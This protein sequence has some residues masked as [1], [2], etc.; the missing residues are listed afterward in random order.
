MS[1]AETFTLLAVDDEPDVVDALRR[2]LKDPRFEFVG[3]TRPAEALEVLT[4]RPV[5]L[6]ISDLDMPGMNGLE[7]LRQVR[8]HHPETVRLVLTGRASLESALDAI[9]QG[10]VHRYLTK[11][12]DKAVLRRTIDDAVDRL[13]EVR[14]AAEAQRRLTERAGIHEALEARYP[15]IT[16]VDLEDGAVPLDPARLDAAWQL[17]DAVGASPADA[18]LLDSE[19][20][21]AAGP[22]DG[23]RDLETLCG[24]VLDERFRLDDLVGSGGFGV[25]YRALQLS[26]DRFVAVKLLRAEAVGRD[27]LKRFRVE[28]L[29][30]CRVAHPHAVTVLDAGVDEQGL[31]YLVME[32]LDGETVAE[33][34]GR[35]DTL[36]F[37][38]AASLAAD[39]CS[40]LSFAHDSGILHCDIK[41]ANVF[42]HAAPDGPVVKLLD[43]GIARLASPQGTFRGLTAENLLMGTPAYMAPERVAGGALD[44]RADVYGMGV[45]LYEML[46][47]VRPFPGTSA[48]EVA[49]QQLCLHPRPLN[50]IDASVPAELD[51][52]VSRMLDKDPA[53]RPT[54]AEAAAALRALLPALPAERMR[55]ASLAAASL[56]TQNEA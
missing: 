40:A 47:G 39:L 3:C 22:G 5:D 7:L 54:A 35:G 52:M 4:S 6:V 46:S 43:F 36:P 2:V 33:R 9:N 44:G 26:L 8:E 21:Q 14:R 1:A 34:L 31:A 48:A 10:E 50:A 20:V 30:A 42:L 13:A 17:A 15:G 29:S 49:R 23:P 25:V 16:R 24:M 41:P 19:A 55:S 32:L 45:L 11:P 53:N 27:Y 28:A 18:W 38:A 51:A 56:T 12:W 37:D